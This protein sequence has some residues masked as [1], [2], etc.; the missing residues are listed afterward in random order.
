[1]SSPF[2]ASSGAYHIT[3]YKFD[4]GFAALK[5]LRV[6]ATVESFN[7][8]FKTLQKYMRSLSVFA[9]QSYEITVGGS[10]RALSVS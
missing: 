5:R 1:M 8:R 6:P 9:S 3:K 7:S 10:R 2:R 4:N